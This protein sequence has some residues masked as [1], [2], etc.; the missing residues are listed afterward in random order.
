MKKVLIVARVEGVAGLTWANKHLTVEGDMAFAEEINTAAKAI[1]NCNFQPITYAP[2]GTSA[3][4]KY[5]DEGIASVTPNDIYQQIGDIHAV[6]LVGMPA[7]SGTQ[8]AFMDGTFNHV[9]WRDYA[10]N[11][12]VCGEIAMLKTYFSHFQIPIVFVSGDVAACQEAKEEIVGVKTVATKRATCRNKA[13]PIEGAKEQIYE[14]CLQ[15]LQEEI[16]P[17]KPLDLPIRIKISYTRTEYCTDAAT[18][19]YRA[20]ATRIDARSLEKTIEDITTIS[21]F[22]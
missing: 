6:V 7:K 15:S 21:V 11:G 3:H 20:S 12:R 1:K 18:R 13:V 16:A 19:W 5:L 10:I 9:G 4:L 17:S 14:T 2:A 22:S 8:N